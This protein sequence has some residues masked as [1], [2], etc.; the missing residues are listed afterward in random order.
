MLAQAESTS[1]C[2]GQTLNVLSVACTVVLVPL[3]PSW[4]QGQQASTSTTFGFLSQSDCVE[5]LSEIRVIYSTRH[6]TQNKSR[7]R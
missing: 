7:H 5:T 1:V 4:Q 3:A 6:T 2:E